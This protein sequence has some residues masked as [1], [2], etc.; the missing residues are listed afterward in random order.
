[1]L[2]WVYLCLGVVLIA[3]V[4]TF[5]VQYETGAS[6]NWYLPAS[7]NRTGPQPKLEVEGSLTHEF[8][9]MS[10]QKEG[11]HKWIVRNRG[12]GDLELWLDGSSCVC[13]IAKLK[14]EG[15]KEV[16]PPGQSTEV[17]LEWKT[18][19]MVG[20]FSKNATIG[21]NDPSRPQFRLNV[22][23]LVHNP[24]VILPEPQEGVVN[25]GVLSS[26]E[27]RSFTLAVFS[28]ERPELKLT[29]LV[30]S[31]PDVIVTRIVP[32]SPADCAKLQTKGGLR[33][34]IEFK[35]GMPLGT[36]R[37]E[38]IIETDHPDSPKVLLTLAGSATGPISVMPSNLR[39]VTVN[40]KD[41]GASQI[42]LMVRE[43]RP[44][45]FT[46]AHK[47]EKIDVSIA[48]TDTTTQKGRYRVTVTVPPGTPAGM[49]DDE[50]VLRT[51]H[52]KVKEL[53]IPVNII[54]GS[55]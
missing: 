36:F 37:E 49:I 9:A 24:V 32:L 40:G 46:I 26:D 3:G 47:P 20:E 22:H 55:G 11:K 27:T 38:L 35:P 29:K 45:S 30:S 41:G 44:T 23:G 2:R 34:V 52:P 15:A 28:P 17:E 8:G 14:K 31:K 5:V 12:E 50:I 18:K 6:T 53:K 7:S 13:T 19:D 33:L 48:S 43:G 1:M 39:M 4:G 51:D 54:V 16:L 10:T 25:V 42:T 21:T